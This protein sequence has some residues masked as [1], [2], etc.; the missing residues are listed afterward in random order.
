[1]PRID[2][3]TSVGPAS[4][5]Y[6]IGTP[7]ETSTTSIVPGLP[8][9][10]LIH[11]VYGNSRIFHL[12]YANPQLRRFNLVS[13]DLRGHGWTSGRIDEDYG[14]ETAA[15]DVLTLMMAIFAPEKVLS[16]FLMSPLP[17]TEPPEIAEGREEVFAYWREA[18]QTPDG[19]IVADG[20]SLDE[21][22]IQ[23]SKIGARQLG[24]NDADTPLR[25]AQV[26]Y[27]YPSQSF[28]FLMRYGMA[29]AM[30]N[31]AYENLGAAYIVTVKFFVNRTPH[32]I[33]ELARIR[34]PVA[35]VHCSADVAYPIKYTEAVQ[36][37]LYRAGIDARSSRS[38]VQRT[39]ATLRIQT[40]FSIF[41]DLP[42][43]PATVESPFLADLVAFGLLEDDDSSGPW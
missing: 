10:L 5:E 27:S 38:K 21:A 39:T 13:M 33:E 24:Y 32:S 2:L 17:L 1:M 3:D 9:V 18:F 29:P 6:T 4:F 35:L 16:L 7:T 8:T 37:L 20:V 36:D 34:C 11:P 41:A 30:R 19:G 12:V 43:V 15:R 25:K 14:R 31:W 26:S 23:D 28:P 42:P 40:I 22:A